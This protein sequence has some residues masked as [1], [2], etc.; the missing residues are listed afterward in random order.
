[1]VEVA[2]SLEAVA[3]LAVEDSLEVAACLETVARLEVADSSFSV[4]LT[5]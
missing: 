3:A 2:A 5:H 4:H 1:M